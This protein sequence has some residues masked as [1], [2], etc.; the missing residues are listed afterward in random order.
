MLRDVSIKV[1]HYKYI[2]MACLLCAVEKMNLDE[3]KIALVAKS[4]SIISE[5]L[6]PQR[7]E[8]TYVVDES[9]T[10]MYDL[11]RGG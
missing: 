11:Q 1:L 5:L 6:T 9:K 7:P 4:E 2:N 10:E 8:S 3:E